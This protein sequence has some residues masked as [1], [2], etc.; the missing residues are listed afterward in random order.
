VFVPLEPFVVNLA[1]R[2][3]DRYAQIGVTL[4]IEDP[5]VADQLKLYMPAIRNGILM[6]MAHKTSVELLERAGKEQLAAE[7]KREAVRP[8]G[9]DLDEPVRAERRDKIAKGDVEDKAGPADAHDD[10]AAAKQPKLKAPPPDSP[11]KQVHFSN[12]II[13]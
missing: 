4:E 9:I 12:F 5:K 2:D 10:E 8:L 11:V 6:V 1:D 13:Q 3:V 7:I